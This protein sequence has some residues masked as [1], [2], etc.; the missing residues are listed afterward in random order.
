MMSNLKQVNNMR[1]RIGQIAKG[2]FEYVKPT[3]TFSEDPIHFN[4]FG[5]ADYSGSFTMNSTHYDR[6]R[7]VVYSTNVRMECLTPQFEGE[8]VMIRYRFHSRGLTEGEVHEG[9]FVIVCNGC[10]YSLPFR[11]KVTKRYPTSSRGEIKSLYDFS[12]LAKENWAEAYQMFYHKSFV[13]L[14]KL[15]EVKEAMIYQGIVAAKPS[16]QNMEEFLIGIRKKERITFSL[17]KNKL[18]FRDLMEDVKEFLT[19]TKDG[20]GFF[21]IHVRTDTE[22]LKPDKNVLTSEDFLGSHCELPF[23]ILVDKLH[24]GN[25]YGRIILESI[26]QTIEAEI[27]VRNIFDWHRTRNRKQIQE[28]RVGIMELYQAY[29]LKRIV[30]GVW[31]NETIEILNHLHALDQEEP[32]YV[33]MKAQALIINRQRQEAEW[34]LDEFG[35]SWTQKRSPVWGYYLYLLSLMEREPSYVDK[36]THEIEMIQRENPD[37]VLL[38]WVLSFL[39]EQYYNNSGQRLRAIERWVLNGCSSPYLYLEAY[40]ILCQEPF[41]LNKLGD[42]EV[43]ILRWAVKNKALN[44]DLA[45]QI[46]SI[47]ELSRS[48]SKVYYRLLC[49][50][51][52]VLPTPEHIGMICSYLIKGQ[53]YATK[54]HSWYEK[55]IELELRITSL[56]EAYLLS[57]DEQVIS[58][59]PKIIQMYFQYESRLPYKNMAVLYNNIIASKQKSPEIYQKYRRNM[60]AF[61][62]EQAEKGRMDDNL[63]VLY[64]EMLDLGLV[65]KEIAHS[66]SHILFTHKLFI[67]DERMVR[68]WI[69][70]RQL[71]EP[72]IVPIV[73]RVAYFQLFS[74]EYV[75]LFEDAGGHRFAG[76]VSYQVQNLMN[77]DPYLKKCMD[78]APEEIPYM[79]SHFDT[80][81]SYLNFSKEDEKFFSRII[82]SQSMS[83]AYKAEMIPEI[84]HYYHIHPSSHVTQDYMR[85]ID[86]AI[87][88]GEARRFF[89]EM[90]VE[91]RMYAETWELVREYG[92]DLLR[93]ESKLAL[94]LY[95]I[96][97]S[98]NAEDE[99]LAGLSYGAF[100][101]GKYNDVLLGYLCQYYSGP[102]EAM[103]M[104]W[105][106]A[107]NFQVETVDIEERI[108]SQML[109]SGQMLEGIEPLFAHFYRN[110]S[111]EMLMLAYVTIKADAYFVQDKETEDLVFDLL[112]RNYLSHKELNDSCKLALL[113]KIASEGSSGG[114]DY[115][116][117]DE[118]LSEFTSRNMVFSFY[119]KMNSSLIQKYHLYDKVILEY[120]TSPQKH[121]VIHYSRDEDGSEFIAEDMVDVYHG[122]FVKQFVMFFGEMI[123]Y[124]ISEEQ[125]NQVEVTQSNRLVNHDVYNHKD[126]SRYSLINQMLMSNTLMEEESLNRYMQRYEELDEMTRQLFRIL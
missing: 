123:Q 110:S 2:K 25:N 37:S 42:F 79:I 12:C 117:A 14:I 32:M 41:L 28:C 21:S 43:R 78:L 17:E 57:M 69:Y 16:N 44:R 20:W 68:V 96:E 49:A 115:Q 121:V 58:N 124:Y 22:F 118:L 31:A 71:K 24:S 85:E 11:A 80:R 46:F 59:V 87:L 34:I 23:M 106:A 111:A 27:T 98:G 122:I 74:R 89:A 102:T 33:L 91:N 82:C 84:L 92:I 66:L 103:F 29:R 95:T 73:D 18:D 30:T 120:R 65:N 86:A 15:K 67:F 38:F 48:F 72:Q 108:L 9:G 83:D 99:F 50:A 61:A 107:E 51:Y 63:A 88:S 10:E 126:E 93:P 4:V 3:I 70:Q 52:E 119:K 104:V 97:Q 114:A 64:T 36:M 47:V 53:Q 54:Y 116:I 62:M 113:K 35:K 6:V 39:E 7:G 55:G 8:E 112:R 26:Y 60:G 77:P 5:D 56:Y 101:E 94:A 13:N 40:Y 105:K 100:S 76:S 75:I 125:R 109:F 19:I 45:E 81:L 1:K 90:L